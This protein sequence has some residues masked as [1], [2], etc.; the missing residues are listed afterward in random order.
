M[1]PHIPDKKIVFMIARS[2]Y[3][4]LLRAGIKIYEFTPG[5]LHS[6]M[7]VSDDCVATV[8]SVNL[9]FRSLFLHFENGVLLYDREIA[10]AA[11][12]DFQQTLAKSERIYLKTYGAFPLYKRAFG[13]LMRVFGPLM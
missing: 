1:L 9:D 5:F 3:P 4:E 12:E 13:R 11:E 2:Y 8:G 10:A 7:F 6:K